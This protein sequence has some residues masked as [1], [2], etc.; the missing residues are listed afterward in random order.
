MNSLKKFMTHLVKN[1]SA[2]LLLY[3]AIFITLNLLLVS[4]EILEKLFTQ[5]RDLI[6]QFVFYQSYFVPKD[7]SVNRMI[8]FNLIEFL[9]SLFLVSKRSK[10]HTFF[11]K[12]QFYRRRGIF[13]V[14]IAMI[15]SA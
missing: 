8:P 7:V 13:A 3:D 2:K 15:T 12:L 10:T 1:I 9:D 14:F 5:K 4:M 11:C 6:C